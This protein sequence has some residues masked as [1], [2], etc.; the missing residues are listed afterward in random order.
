MSGESF[1]LPRW[2][3]PGR[4]PNP[5]VAGGPGCRRTDT[6][7]N[8]DYGKEGHADFDEVETI[9]IEEARDSQEQP[10]PLRTHS[11]SMVQA[12][13]PA[14]PQFEWRQE[15]LD[16]LTIRP[17]RAGRQERISTAKGLSCPVPEHPQSVRRRCRKCSHR[18]GRFR[19][20]GPGGLVFQLYRA[21]VLPRRGRSSGGADLLDEA[22]TAVGDEAATNWRH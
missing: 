5:S 7:N 9:A 21:R 10:R 22:R 3:P 1:H 19:E 6:R 18:G 15:A 17:V 2:A 20:S 13:F 16:F 12:S 14:P 4:H 11:P 8:P